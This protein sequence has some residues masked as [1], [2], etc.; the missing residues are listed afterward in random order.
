MNEPSPD[1]DDRRLERLVRTSLS[2]HAERLGPQRSRIDDV[3]ERVA[4]RR[5]RRRTGTA[6]GSLAIA[7]VGVAGL[8]ALSR[9][10]GQQLTGADGL[11]IAASSTTTATD[12][13]RTLPETDLDHWWACTGELEQVDDITYYA[14]CEA[15]PFP[16][17]I[18]ELSPSTTVAFPLG[19]GVDVER[20][21]TEQQYVVVA[22]DSIYGIASRF[23]V[24]PDVLVNYNEWPDRLDHVIRVGDEVLIPPGGRAL[25]P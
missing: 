7:V 15:V 21:A 16:E 19:V 5:R 23:G 14:R 1:A 17:H 2:H 10:G 13:T 8:V 25:T 4:H 22:G 3:F 24:E 6:V 11:P 18:D 12:D 9:D 20:S